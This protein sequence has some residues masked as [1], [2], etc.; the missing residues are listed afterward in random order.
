MTEALDQ[1]AAGLFKVKDRNPEMFGFAYRDPSETTRGYQG[2]M[3]FITLE[4]TRALFR[5]SKSEAQ[6]DYIIEQARQRER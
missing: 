6:I 5:D 4:E 1:I 3:K 2:T